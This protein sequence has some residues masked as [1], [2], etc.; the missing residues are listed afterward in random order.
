[1]KSKKLK[2]KLEEGKGSPGGKCRGSKGFD[3]EVEKCDLLNQKNTDIRNDIIGLLPSYKRDNVICFT[4]NSVE[5]TRRPLRV[6]NGKLRITKNDSNNISDM[7]VHFRDEH[8]CMAGI[9]FH[10]T[11]YISQK[12][13]GLV[14]FINL[15][16]NNGE[17]FRESCIKN[18]EVSGELG[19]CILETL[20]ID[21]LAFCGVFNHYA[22]N[23]ISEI[24][25]VADMHNQTINFDS[26]ICSNSFKENLQ[27]FL[28]QCMGDGDM[29]ISHNISD[30]DILYRSNKVDL[31]VL[32]YNSYYG[33]KSKRGKR[34]NIEI[35]TKSL[36]FTINIRNKQGNIYPSHIMCDFKYHNDQTSL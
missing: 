23:N 4:K 20:G 25:N 13:S 21:K 31:D 8:N 34:I 16:V 17:C 10:S 15:G 9:L 32:R 7:R 5:N 33:G 30:K 12:S 18:N 6:E 11:E 27:G 26:N 29:I 14:T 28:N 36:I 19:R 22:M 3:I 2:I 1:V 24:E 35:A